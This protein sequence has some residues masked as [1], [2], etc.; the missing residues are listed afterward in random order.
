[1]KKTIATLA[2]AVAATVASPVFAKA[3]LA[4]KLQFDH[5]G[6]TYTYSKTQVGE[7]TIYKGYA[8]PGDAFYLVARK[9]QVTGKANGVAVSF[10]APSVEMSAGAKMIPLAS[11]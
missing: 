2:L 6:V 7:S 11:R 3:E 1:M 5:E 10:R 4:P 9:G 8:S